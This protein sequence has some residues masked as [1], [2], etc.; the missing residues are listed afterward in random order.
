MNAAAPSI[1]SLLF[2]DTW[3]TF[4][5]VGASGSLV[6]LTALFIVQFRR[7]TRA[8]WAETGR[9]YQ[10]ATARFLAM[11]DLVDEI[12]FETDA[13]RTL[14]YTNK[15]FRAFT[16]YRETDL[17]SGL[18]LADLFDPAER[19]HLQ[20]DLE[21]SPG[22]DEVRVRPYQL[23]CRDGAVMPVSLRLT[24]ITGTGR[25]VGWR[26]VAEPAAPRTDVVASGR[27]AR[28]VEEILGR[29]L[30]DFNDAPGDRAS[31]AITRAL[32]DIGDALGADRCYHYETSADGGSLLSCHQWYAPDVSPMTGDERLPGLDR[33]P[34]T[35]AR[36]REDGAVAVTDINRLDAQD[37]PE[38][39]R[40]RR[41]GIG[42][43]LV[44]P[45]HEGRELV[46]IIGCET[47]GRTRAWGPRDR[48]M[49]EAMAEICQRARTVSRT[50]RE[51]VRANDRAIDLADL[52]PEPVAV[53]DAAGRVVVW[54]PPL[55]ALS[56][57][58]A[59]DAL[60]AEASAVVERFLPGCGVWLRREQAEADGQ[61]L[62]A[63]S[64]VV[65]VAT[66]SGR[67]AWVQLSRR[68]LDDGAGSLLHFCDVTETR[69]ETSRMRRRNE[70]LERAVVNQQAELEQAQAQLVETEKMAAVARMVTG[71]AQ[72]I[73]TPVG[74]G[75]T[76]SSHLT[77]LSDNLERAYRDGLMRRSDFEDFLSAAR[78]SSRL[79]QENLQ[80]ASDLLS[81]MRRAAAG[82][83]REQRREIRL[84]EYLDDVIQ[85]LRPR[86][87]DKNVAVRFDCPDDLVVA[88]EPDALYRIVSNLCSNAVQHAFDG[89]LLGEIHI[90]VTR[91]DDQVRLRFAD[92][93]C[94]ID[95]ERRSRIFE[96]FF[97]TARDSGGLGLGLHV[98]YSLV[99]RNLG[100]TLRCDSAPG[101]GTVFDIAF[102]GVKDAP[103]GR[104]TV[105]ESRA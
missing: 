26:G 76:A 7:Q 1:L 12:L 78:E 104:S 45:M 42:S 62:P 59:G 80:C 70:D 13:S 35:M 99:T 90:E 101:Q 53:I 18:C 5:L 25:L 74:V 23:R 8:A 67:T 6:A 21:A 27:P 65:E 24:P 88:I 39:G 97:T 28:A 49:L 36:L 32:G 85:N 94:G 95:R 69:A 81:S 48:Q 10:D 61:N 105:S 87:R 4:L 72:E 37:I 92:N 100:G 9:V 52:L 86:L 17:R 60:G 38:L 50:E 103:H 54:N 63:A 31:A 96:P 83:A 47:L 91:A 14:T 82:Q 64:N 102:P 55:A 34:W 71:L 19:D 79:I 44:V 3:P 20:E 93:G 2:P 57:I 73:N 22:G 58:A 84:R 89:M 75:L 56:G 98:V 40:W 30:R 77:D 11:G 29:I 68:P 15:A 43:L 46:G 51:L 16:G 66:P 41:Q 33:Y